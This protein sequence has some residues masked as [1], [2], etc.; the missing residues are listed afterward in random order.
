MLQDIALRILC[1]ALRYFNC[2]NINKKHY[3]LCNS[4]YKNTTL[5]QYKEHLQYLIR[6]RLSAFAFK[7]APAYSLTTNNFNEK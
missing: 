5:L 6:R 4:N 3:S 7:N 2:K 1:E